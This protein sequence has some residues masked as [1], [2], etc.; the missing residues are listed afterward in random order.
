LEGFGKM[1]CVH[2]KIQSTFLHHSLEIRAPLNLEKDPWDT[3][4]NGGVKKGVSLWIS[5]TIRRVITKRAYNGYSTGEIH[6][7][8]IQTYSHKTARIKTLK[9]TT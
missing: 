9:L 1:F 7:N 3:Y 6:P 4:L 8:I 2:P 5:Y